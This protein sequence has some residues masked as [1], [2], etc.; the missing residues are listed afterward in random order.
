MKRSAHC[1][2]RLLTWVWCLDVDIQRGEGSSTD[3]LVTIEITRGL[4][5]GSLSFPLMLDDPGA[6]VDVEMM[7]G[8]G[9]NDAFVALKGDLADVNKLL[10]DIDYDTP[11]NMRVLKAY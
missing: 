9:R 1:E 8:S 3:V 7:A 6:F 4:N 5:G 11:K 10:S 2:H